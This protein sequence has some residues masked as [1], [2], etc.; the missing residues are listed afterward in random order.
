MATRAILS[1]HAVSGS[2]QDLLD[3]ALEPFRTLH[4]FSDVLKLGLHEPVSPTKTE[5]TKK[6]FQNCSSCDEA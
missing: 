2:Q 5:C 1:L 6:L 4:K 3:F